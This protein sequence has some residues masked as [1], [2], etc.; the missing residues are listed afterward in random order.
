MA[1]GELR[2]E[3]VSLLMDSDSD[4]DP[5]DPLWATLEAAVNHAFPTPA[6]SLRKLKAVPCH[7]LPCKREQKP[8]DGDEER[9]QK[10][11]RRVPAVENN[12]TQKQKIGVKHN[13]GK[14]TSL[15]LLS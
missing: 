14:T 7:Q 11:R 6:L 12:N 1:W 2:R 5:D 13:T 9:A 4:C 10:K 15:Y 8:A 3:M